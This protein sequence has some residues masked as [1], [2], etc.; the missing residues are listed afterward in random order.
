[1]YPLIYWFEGLSAS[2]L[3]WGINLDWF[4]VA[5]SLADVINKV[6]FGLTAYFA[7][8][9][10]SGDDQESR[11]RLPQDADGSSALRINTGTGHPEGQA[12]K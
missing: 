1:V 4:N 11:E 2:H 8:K 3:S 9:A 7:V 6:G 10:L 12:E 5:G